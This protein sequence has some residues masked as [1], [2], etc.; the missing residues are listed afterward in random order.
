MDTKLKCPKCS[1]LKIIDEETSVEIVQK[2]I[3]HIRRL[4]KTELDK[5]HRDSLLLHL[6]VHRETQAR[7]FF[8]QPGILDIDSFFQ[9][10]YLSEGF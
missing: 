9:I 5:I 10:P 3:N 4:W 2:R 7:K 8:K 1:D 6:L